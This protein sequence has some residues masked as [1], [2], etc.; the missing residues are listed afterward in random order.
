MSFTFKQQ[1]PSKFLSTLATDSSGTQ[2]QCDFDN[3]HRHAIGEKKLSMN[4]TRAH[5]KCLAYK[6][7]HAKASEEVIAAQ[8][9][10]SPA[11]LHCTGKL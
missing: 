3:F 7:V 5:K 6:V 2:E 9:Y 10:I 1:S 4:S 8:G 11:L